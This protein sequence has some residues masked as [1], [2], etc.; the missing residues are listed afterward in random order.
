[1][2][3]KAANDG[4]MSRQKIVARFE[5]IASLISV[6]LQVERISSMREWMVSQITNKASV[7]GLCS[8]VG[9]QPW[10]FGY[11]LEEQIS[12]PISKDNPDRRPKY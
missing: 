9:L 4:A 7:F 3:A 12:N 2:Q 1:M 10:V 11:L 6:G 8:P 5:I